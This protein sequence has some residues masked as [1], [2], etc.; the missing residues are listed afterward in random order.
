[1]NSIEFG[2]LL[3]VCVRIC[4]IITTSNLRLT[5][6]GEIG[7]GRRPDRSARRSACMHNTKTR[8]LAVTLK[9]INERRGQ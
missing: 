7:P 2:I 6:R 8:I 3:H 4:T 5:N 9:S 1:M